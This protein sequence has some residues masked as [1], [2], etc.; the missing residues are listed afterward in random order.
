MRQCLQYAS[1]GYLFVHIP[2]C[3]NHI[4]SI[5]SPTILNL[6][7]KEDLFAKENDMQWTIAM[8]LLIKPWCKYILTVFAI[9]M[10]L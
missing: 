7:Y 4:G 3:I 10:S 6:M 2:L 5:I 1:F 9:K 8:S